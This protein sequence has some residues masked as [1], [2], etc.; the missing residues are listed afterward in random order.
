MGTR[1]PNRIIGD[2]C[3]SQRCVR[4]LSDRFVLIESVTFDDACFDA[5]G[6]TIRCRPWGPFEYLP[7]A[8]IVADEVAATEPA[9]RLIGFPEFFQN[10]T[11][12]EWQPLTGDTNGKDTQLRP[13]VS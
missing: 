9:T 3:L 10:F 8:K 13:V 12:R 11:V 2:D 5:L 6:E 7:I 4:Q 1:V